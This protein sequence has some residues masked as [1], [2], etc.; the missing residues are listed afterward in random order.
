MFFCAVPG[1]DHEDEARGDC[2]FEE[3]LEGAEDHQVGPVLGGG[4]GDYADSWMGEG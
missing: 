2:A 3:T 1:P 4:D